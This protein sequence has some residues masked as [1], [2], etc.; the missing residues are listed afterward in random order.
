MNLKTSIVWV[1]LLF[2]MALHA[3]KSLVK[4]TSIYTSAYFTPSKN[5]PSS[6]NK[7]LNLTSYN[8]VYLNFNDLDLNL[9][10]IPFRSQG[11]QP[12]KLIYDDYK[13]YRDEYLLKG[14][15]LA[16]DPTRWNLQCPSPL[17]VQPNK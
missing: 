8:F 9:I 3:Q 14:F 4:P 10:A 17:S 12:S 5:L 7:R 1:F 13:A 6:L 16:N 2:G 11:N 15:L